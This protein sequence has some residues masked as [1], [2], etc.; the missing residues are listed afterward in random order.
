MALFSSYRGDSGDENREEKINA[1]N[2]L[3]NDL[4]VFLLSVIFLIFKYYYKVYVQINGFFLL[5]L[6]N[7]SFRKSVLIIIIFTFTE[8]AN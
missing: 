2:F 5:F 6:W 8:L 7:S 1:L 4:F 3:S